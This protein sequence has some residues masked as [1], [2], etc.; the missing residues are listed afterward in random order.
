[1]SLPGMSLPN[2]SA[3]PAGIETLL[4]SRETRELPATAAAPPE[5][6]TPPAAEEAPR[7]SKTPF[8]PRIEGVRAALGDPPSLPGPS[9]GEAPQAPSLMDYGFGLLL[10]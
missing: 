10:N 9:F 4:E 8:S 3:A 7:T 5:I 2:A 1:M 6:G